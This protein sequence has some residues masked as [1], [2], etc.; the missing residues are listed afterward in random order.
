MGAIGTAIRDFCY[1]CV[2]DGDMTPIFEWC[3]RNQRIVVDYPEDMLVLTAVRDN[4][5]GVYIEPATGYRLL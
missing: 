1:D 3:S 5:E 2:I 4:I